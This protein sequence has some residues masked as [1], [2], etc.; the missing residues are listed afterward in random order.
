MCQVIEC[1]AAG[2]YVNEEA[3]RAHLQP[4]KVLTNIPE[5]ARITAG[6]IT[7]CLAAGRYGNVEAHCAHL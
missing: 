5:K 2:R 1:L 3:Q 4:V 7:K 6:T